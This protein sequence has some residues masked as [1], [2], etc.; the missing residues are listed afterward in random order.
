M[1]RPV[2]HEY[3]VGHG[4]C[5]AGRAGGDAQVDA[6][7]GAGQ[8]GPHEGQALVLDLPVVDGTPALT[9]TDGQVL[10][11]PDRPVFREGGD[12]TL[13]DEDHALLVVG[14]YLSTAHR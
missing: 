14:P 4:L 11:A 12:R 5:E 13:P 10:K 7:V 1:H 6:E 2:L 3:L 8:E 9:G